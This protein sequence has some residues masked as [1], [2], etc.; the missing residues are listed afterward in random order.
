MHAAIAIEI[1]GHH[2]PV[3][4]HQAQLI[5]KPRLHCGQIAV[6]EKRLRIRPDQFHIQIL[7][8]VI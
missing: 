1:S 2:R 6:P 8:Q 4:S 3:K 5:E 7:K